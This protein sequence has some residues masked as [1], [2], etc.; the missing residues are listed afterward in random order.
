M[1]SQTSWLFCAPTKKRNS[2]KPMFSLKF[3]QESKV[4]YLIKSLS[5]FFFF[6]FF[7]ANT[8]FLF[9]I[10]FLICVVSLTRWSVADLLFEKSRLIHW[11]YMIQF[12]KL[13]HSRNND[14]FHNL[15]NTRTECNRPITVYFC[16]GFP[17]LKYRHCNDFF[18]FFIIIFCKRSE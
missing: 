13:W 7:L 10:C 1:N 8:I 6:F 16:M 5:Y 17:L 3:E 18:F 14:L 11:K 12:T 15:S 9:E 4:P 2:E